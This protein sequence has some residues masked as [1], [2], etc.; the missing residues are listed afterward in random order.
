MKQNRRAEARWNGF[1]SRENV[2]ATKQSSSHC[3]NY[4]AK[5]PYFQCIKCQWDY[6]K[7]AV[8]GICQGCLRR[9]EH[10]VRS[11]NALRSSRAE[12]GVRQ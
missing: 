4:T 5:R 9:G 2:P 11:A 1:G 8:D 10:T 7:V 12:G 6:Q 3:N